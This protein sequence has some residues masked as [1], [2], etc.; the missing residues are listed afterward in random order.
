MTVSSRAISTPTAPWHKASF[1][2]FIQ[3]KLPQL[4]DA[5]LPLVS[6]A[7]EPDGQHTC[8]ITIVLG[9]TA[10]NITLDYPA[11]P[12]PDDDGV[13][14]VD[15]RQWV[16]IPVA[17]EANLEQA[18]IKCVGELLYDYCDAR[19]S[20]APQD[21]P[22]DE[23][24]ARAWLP[25]DQWFQDFLTEDPRTSIQIT[26]FPDGRPENQHTNN[27]IEDL[28]WLTRQTQLRRII[29]LSPDTKTRLPPR[30]VAPGQMGRVCPIETP[31][32]PN[33][34]RVRH[35]ARG[36]EIRD[37]RLI[38]V[39]DRPE[40]AIGLSPSMIPFL[41]H[42][43][44]NRTLMGANMMRQ[45]VPLT[46]P[47][48]AL[49]QSGN[50]P[51][52]PEFW[53]GR[54][55]LTAFVSWDI[56][57]FEDGLVIS[58][59][60]AQRL[61]NST[62]WDPDRT[63]QPAEP[64][65]KLSNR[66]GNKGVVSQILPDDEMPHLA[67]GTPV[68]LIMSIMSIPSRMNIGQL[69]EAVMGRIARTSGEPAVVP[70][71]HA[72]N[73]RELRGR[74]TLADL[75][76]DGM[77]TLILNGRPLERPSTVGWVYWGCTQHLARHKIHAATN[78]DQWGQLRGQWEYYMLRN[79]GAYE[80]INEAN[81]TLAYQR[82]GAETV[83]ERVAQ[84]PIEQ[85]GPPT[86][87][88]SLLTQRLGA[89]GVHAALID[90]QLSFR[91][92]QPDGDVLKLAHTAPH[93]WLPDHQI[94]TIGIVDSI[95]GYEA[96]REANTRVERMLA[97][98]APD[99]LVQK[100]NEQLESYVAQLFSNLLSPADLYFNTRVLFSGRTVIVPGAKIGQPPL[101]YDQAGIPDEMAWTLFGPLVT[102]ELGGADAV[103]DRTEQAAKTLDDIMAHS[104]VVLMRTPVLTPTGLIA[105]R[106]VRTSDHAI[107]LHP[108]ACDLMNAD[109]DGDQMAVFLPITKAA[110]KEAEERLSITGHLKRDRDLV[111]SFVKLK[112][113]L[114]G[115]ALLSRTAEGKK[116][117]DRLVGIEVD[118]SEGFVS[119][120]TMVDAMRCV[121]DREGAT[122]TLDRLER[123]M[124]RG[125]EVAKTSGASISPF[126]GSSLQRPPQPAHDDPASWTVYTEEFRAHIASCQDYDTPD[127]GPLLLASR[128][129]AR[130]NM[131]QLTRIIGGGEVLGDVDGVRIPIRHG[132]VEGLT[133][134]E[135]FAAAC[136]GRER[137]ASLL[138]EMQ[139]VSET[140][141]ATHAPEGYH[142]LARAMRAQHPGIVF[143]RAAATEEADPLN[144]VDSR[145]FVGLPVN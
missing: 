73:E 122:G 62:P 92:A 104:W 23:S 79:I 108:F 141:N 83:A 20:E 39:D 35:V 116:E 125:F 96:L 15:G 38:I 82:E 95:D 124:Y 106:P 71:F 30:V 86:P 133:A 110:Q 145:L 70:P 65:D 105:C 97:G 12:H 140:F 88:L 68:E 7:A 9:T 80:T 5:R 55:L 130:G 21:M 76:E 4:L 128:S 103:R 126:V 59:S 66:H 48:P 100:A 101:H 94:E 63:D 64:G 75:P 87:M 111:D 46:E 113:A 26:G 60:C 34:G 138:R 136:D 6:Y 32:G 67:D 22:W 18:E 43:D 77:E 98:H 42:N 13:F 19:L 29:I 134:E 102:R 36:A 93:P 132:Y 85:A 115:L 8:R 53:Q 109:F 127:M 52:A 31:E 61:R 14:D 107:H 33:I 58:A 143:T 51:D 17:S 37:G 45:W 135:I 11:L 89:A 3:E 90:E 112:D 119:G 81:N 123:L 2:A 25:L 117:I 16:V 74:L 41:E 129:G 57:T 10:K 144:D 27:R 137:I 49:V 54:N 84:G 142:V 120:V 78:P 28:N 56:G 50:E 24:F 44:P 47:E 131:N 121:L 40:A 114:F 118:A 69:H 99:S 139:G 1:D 91:L 72:P